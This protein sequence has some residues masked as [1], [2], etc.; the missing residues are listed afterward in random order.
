MVEPLAQQLQWGLCK[1][2]LTLWHVEVVYEHHAALAS[3]RA[4]HTLAAFVHLGVCTG[5]EVRDVW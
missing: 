3:W 2:P 5:R 1:V 4:K